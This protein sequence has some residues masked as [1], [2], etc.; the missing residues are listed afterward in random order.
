[1][2][3]KIIQ[4]ISILFIFLIGFIIHNLYE[5]CPNIVT[6]ILS[7]VNESVFEHM[8]MIY[9]S[10]IIWII[11]KY[12]ILKKYNIKENNFLLKELLTFLFN[13]ALFLTIYWPIYSKF[14]ENMLVTL[15]IYL[16][17]II[18]SQI[19][20]YFIEF[21]KDSNVLNIISL[22]VIFLI[23]AFTTYLTYNPPICKLFLDPTN[24]SYGLNKRVSSKYFNI[25]I[26][27]YIYFSFFN[28]FYKP[29]TIY[30]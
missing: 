3:K 20:N 25:F 1:M 14:G 7:P 22:I 16:V 8:K 11:V 4:I 27:I 10:Y 29:K 24:N 2:K 17:T 13:I 28:Y 30:N 19:L 15:T 18:I 6:L 21:K 9:T 5:W 26:Y 23:Y 12:F